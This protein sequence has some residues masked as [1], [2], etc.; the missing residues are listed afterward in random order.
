MPTRH[1]AIQRAAR[2]PA[3]NPE[4]KRLLADLREGARYTRPN[5]LLIDEIVRDLKAAQQAYVPEG[6]GDN[7]ALHYLGSALEEIGWL[8]A[9]I[10]DPMAE[11]IRDVA[12]NFTSMHK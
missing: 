12:R 2:L 11:K 10:G 4:R 5:R 3:G 9:E 7:E 8:I 1:E 6:D